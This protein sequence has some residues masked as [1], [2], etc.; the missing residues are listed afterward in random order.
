MSSAL[1]LQS[2]SFLTAM[3]AW[4]LLSV[5]LVFVLSALWV[6]DAF[7]PGLNSDEEGSNLLRSIPGCKICCIVFS[8]WSDGAVCRWWRCLLLPARPPRPEEPWGWSWMW[9]LIFEVD[10]WIWA[11][12]G[13]RR[14]LIKMSSPVTMTN[15]TLPV[16][17]LNLACVGAHWELI[18]V[19][20]PCWGSST[21]PV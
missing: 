21:E 11:L 1:F 10:P 13:K 20:S 14:H 5:L 3:R 9:W 7:E 2:P 16:P 19:F 18:S 6:Q 15:Y 4:I 8:G 17:K 12:Q